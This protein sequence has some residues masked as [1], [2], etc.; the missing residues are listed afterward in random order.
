M[1]TCPQ[2]RKVFSNMVK[3][4]PDCKIPL[5]D[6][7]GGNTACPVTPAA[8][9][10]PVTPVTPVTPVAPV[11]PDT[12]ITP[13]NPNNTFNRSNPVSPIKPSVGS[14]PADAPGFMESVKLFFSHYADFRTRS[15]RREFWFA[16][17]FNTVIIL[18]IYAM[19]MAGLSS[20]N[21][22]MASTSSVLLMVYSL[23]ILVPSLAISVRR[24]HDVGK[25][26]WLY[27]L[28]IIP[29]LG[30]IILLIFFCKDSTEDNQWGPNPKHYA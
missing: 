2:C 20:E 4:C 11:T 12:P 3:V 7:A 30:S 24:L 21:T 22:A 26:G 18:I 27:L 9:V 10:R 17:I 19:G 29:Y 16:S 8:P 28:N 13:A 25:S 5:P 15:R 6:S 23:A 1:K 14:I